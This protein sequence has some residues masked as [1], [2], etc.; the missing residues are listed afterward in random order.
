[1][2][3]YSARGVNSAHTGTITA[4]E[5]VPNPPN[6][7]DIAIIKLRLIIRMR[8]EETFFV[9]HHPT[10]RNIGAQIAHRIYISF[11]FIFPSIIVRSS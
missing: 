2:P 6:P 4:A 10:K 8:T 1:M 5:S 3:L 9:I 7:H 11:K